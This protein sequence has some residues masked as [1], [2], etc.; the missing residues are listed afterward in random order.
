MVQ[1]LHLVDLGITIILLTISTFSYSN[2]EFIYG[3]T[4]DNY[5]HIY[6]TNYPNTQLGVIVREMNRLHSEGKYEEVILL[7]KSALD[8]E[9]DNDLYF[10]LKYLL[11]F[12][13]NQYGRWGDELDEIIE[14]SNKLNNIENDTIRTYLNYYLIKFD[15]KTVNFPFPD[16]LQST[17]SSIIKKNINEL[18]LIAHQLGL[19]EVEIQ[20]ERLMV[21]RKLMKLNLDQ[22]LSWTLSSEND[23]L[24]VGRLGYLP[25]MEGPVDND[26]LNWIDMGFNLLNRCPKWDYLQR[27]QYAVNILVCSKLSGNESDFQ[28]AQKEC[29]DSR[30][31]LRDIEVD[32][33]YYTTMLELSPFLDKDS[34]ISYSNA[35]VQ[36]LG[37]VEKIRLSSDYVQYLSSKLVSNISIIAKQRRYLFIISIFLSISVIIVV[38]LFVLLWKRQK[39][40]NEINILQ[41]GL[42][43]SVSHDIRVPLQQSINLLKDHQNIDIDPVILDLSKVI[44]HI[45]ETTIQLKTG[46]YR[47]NYDIQSLVR[48]TLSLYDNSIKRKNLII[49]YQMSKQIGCQPIPNQNF[50]IAIRNLLLN[51]I[52]HNPT[53]GY[54]LIDAEIQQN[55]L[56]L[57]IENSTWEEN[58]NIDLKG[59]GL[60]LIN[61]LMSD[62]PL[63][64]DLQTSIEK[65]S[66]QFRLVWRINS[67]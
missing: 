52:E 15:I 64:V 44:S 30:Q 34:V 46:R 3:I 43:S 32:N 17:E 7:I 23:S 40:L 50:I 5:P 39:K 56:Q 49:K 6:E 60:N 8:E 31:F 28:T 41:R 19:N 36:G 58:R 55:N 22:V 2:K 67:N 27:F 18:T 57:L 62:Q 38:F 59:Q 4:I 24:H 42:I 47:R 66:I 20:L 63:F 53:D 29:L 25:W 65:D 48:E 21:S 11:L 35:L 13:Y 54:V 10:K 37:K 14:L 45:N 9:T 1:N 12:K 33:H 16:N 26:T 51:A 61:L